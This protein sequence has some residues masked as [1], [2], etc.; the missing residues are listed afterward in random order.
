M[1]KIDIV[2][3]ERGYELSRLS[4]L[5]ETEAVRELL[6]DLAT[7]NAQKLE[8]KNRKLP[9]SPGV[10]SEGLQDDG[11]SRWNWMAPAITTM[12]QMSPEL[13]EYALSDYTSVLKRYPLENY[14]KTNARY[15]LPD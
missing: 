6:L 13:G 11:Y 8:L 7:S 10:T 1:E 15:S 14:E 3:T 12:Q 9:E 4:G 2:V 5:T